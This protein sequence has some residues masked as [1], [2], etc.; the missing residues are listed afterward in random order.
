MTELPVTQGS[1]L[2]YATLTLPE[3]IRLQVLLTH[4]LHDEINRVPVTC[5]DPGVARIKLEWWREELL[6]YKNDQARHPLT[7]Q[8]QSL[9][10]T[11]EISPERLLRLV[12]AT[13]DQLLPEPLGTH[14]DWCEFIDAGPAQPWI[15]TAALCGFSDK[16]TEDVLRDLIRY[17]VWVDLLQDVYPLAQR[18][19]CYIPLD[20]LREYGINPSG[21]TEDIHKE[22]FRTLLREEYIN[23]ETMLASAYRDLPQGERR[24]LL[25][26][27]I[28]CQLNRALCREVLESSLPDPALRTA[29]T[30]LRRAWITWT[31]RLTNR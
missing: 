26:L 30:P 7:R 23:S 6:R 3:S 29:L 18:G 11:G 2:Y 13:E 22:N 21:I 16:N 10:A 5:S 28:L 17:S 14:N 8:L 1:T 9:P 31:T 19:R 25:P 12:D 27:L 15:I 20:K 24:K 4:A